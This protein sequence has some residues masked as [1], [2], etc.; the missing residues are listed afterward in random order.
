MFLFGKVSLVAMG[1]AGGGCG[2]VHRG[3]EGMEPRGTEAEEAL[4]GRRRTVR[5]GSC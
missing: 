3:V 4:S 5:F 1:R 2:V